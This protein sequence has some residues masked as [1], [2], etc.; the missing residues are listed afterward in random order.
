MNNKLST[1]FLPKTLLLAL[2]LFVGCFAHAEILYVVNSQ[3]RTL[4]RIDTAIDAVNNSFATLGNVPNKIVVD[5]NHVWSVNSGDNAV[6]KISRVTGASLGNIHLGNGSNPWDAVK[7]TDNLYV[8]GLFSGKVY[9]VDT[10]SGSVIASVNV[11]TA[12]EA[13]LVIGDRLY[14]S[15][16]GN[17]AQNYAGSSVSVIDLASFSV[18]ATIPVHKNPQY[19]AEHN[20]KLHVSCTGNWTDVGGAICIIDPE[21]NSLIHTIEV[22][23]TPGCIWIQ[24]AER[25]LV[26][27]SNGANL[28]SYHPGTF[29]LLH[30]N[31]N[32]IPNGGS[33]IVGNS[34]MVAV[35]SPA[36]GGNGTVK[37]LHS[38]L[39][40]MK[41][42]TV[43][44]M[45][46]DMKL[47]LGST[48]NDDLVMQVSSITAYP[49]PVKQGG[50]IKL[51][52]QHPMQGRLNIYNLKGQKVAD[53][54]INAKSL[55][56][57]TNNLTSG[58]YFYKLQD[59]HSAKQHLIG[60]FIV[61]N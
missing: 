8:S 21:S 32:P 44:M 34:N 54:G 48:A 43:G 61:L 6:Q 60:K 5:E 27:D 24:G 40:D 50:S 41:Q 31:S 26:A 33:E 14:V 59:E 19:L 46:T 20:G 45:P 51:N 47:G 57:P 11:G 42:Y 13:L 18:I 23:G 36:W 55:E 29:D 4:S 30:G 25:A 9:K 15:N 7:H 49:N 38:D 17:Y 1:N 35:L 53:Y 12:P 10:I 37:L 39:S 58:I 2:M 52:S 16:A 22:G 3:S 56:L 28:F